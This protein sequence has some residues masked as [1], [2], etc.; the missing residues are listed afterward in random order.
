[1]ASHR[2]VLERRK[3]EASSARLGHRRRSARR[4]VA[5][6]CVP[7]VVLAVAWLAA[8]LPAAASSKSLHAQLDAA[9][10]QG[11][12][13][14]GAPAATATVIRC[15]KVVW[16]GADGVVDIT[17][18]RPA[19]PTT[20]FAIASSTKSITAALVLDLVERGKLSLDTKVT[21]FFP[22]LPQ[23]TKI[24]VRMLLDHTSG[25]NEYFD[26]PHISDTILHEPGHHWT[27]AEVLRAVTKTLFEPGTQYS[28]SN[29]AYV[30]LGGIIEQLT[31]DTIEHA[32]HSR[33]A[34]PLD[35]EN[36]TF[37][38]RPTQS[39]LFAHPYLRAGG[40]LQDAFA[41]G[42]GV[43]SDYWGPV[44]TDGGVAST[45]PDLARFG[46]ALFRGSLVSTE[47]LR[48]MTTPN[49]F[50][51]RLGIDEQ[52]FG[53]RTWLGHNGRY[54]GYESEVWF[55]AT[56]GVTIAVNT[57]AEVSSLATWQAIVTAYDHARPNGRPCRASGDDDRDRRTRGHDGER[58]KTQP[59]PE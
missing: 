55:D 34:D 38:Y 51:S 19:T 25:L 54:G 24:T 17:S 50:G 43:P 46:D 9:L 22:A 10:I 23:A 31:G 6:V 49:S 56:R 4:R 58:S 33:I 53:G 45:S 3:L 41:P 40:A 35:L 27:R 15:G 37:T 32:F 26:D 57:N 12:T 39:F 18:K 1:V 30:V 5:R 42:I 7:A 21:R 28:Y 13:A 59:E 16:S 48:T 44:W 20:R 36:S 8:A 14:S 47:T 52:P 11:R 29:S 2:T